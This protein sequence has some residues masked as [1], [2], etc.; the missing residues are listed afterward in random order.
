VSV[1]VRRGSIEASDLDGV[2]RLETGIGDVDVRRAR[3]AADG[4][5]RLRTFNGHVRL[6]FAAQPADAR[7]LALTLNGDITSTIP[8]TRKDRVGPRFAEATLG[9]GDPLVSIDVVTGNITITTP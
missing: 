2:V 9:R 4:L 3:L 8:L 6:G 5:I 1:H 7:I